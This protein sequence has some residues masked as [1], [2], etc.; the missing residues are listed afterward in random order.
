MTL[1]TLN[2]GNYGIFL[3]M[4]NAGFCPST[5]GATRSVWGGGGFRSSGLGGLG[6]RVG[7]LGGLGFRGLG[8]RVC[9]TGN[10]PSG[11]M[12]Q[13]EDTWI[14]LQTSGIACSCEYRGRPVQKWF[15]CTLSMA[16]CFL[17]LGR[18]N[19]VGFSLRV[20]TTL[21]NLTNPKPEALDLGLTRVSKTLHPKP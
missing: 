13:T 4:G 1:R 16:G 21:P 17:H 18:R 8:F 20:W 12:S 14:L 6:F 5:I 7:G 9:S 19:F 10:R 15:A 2:Y 11:F 3:I